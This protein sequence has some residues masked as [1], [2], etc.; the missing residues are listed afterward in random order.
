MTMTR[1]TAKPL[2]RN[3]ALAGLAAI[4]YVMFSAPHDFLICDKDGAPCFW[5]SCRAHGCMDDSKTDGVEG[6]R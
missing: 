2:S 3:A 5:P 1:R 6:K 4:D